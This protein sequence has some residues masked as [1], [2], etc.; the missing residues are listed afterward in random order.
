MISPDVMNLNV[1][2]YDKK[3]ST[4]DANFHVDTEYEPV[5]YTNGILGTWWATEKGITFNGANNTP[6]NSEFGLNAD[7][8]RVYPDASLGIPSSDMENGYI[9]DEAVGKYFVFS[10]I[11]S[12]YGNRR[13]HVGQNGGIGMPCVDFT[14]SACNHKATI[15]VTSKKDGRSCSIDIAC[16]YYQP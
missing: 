3:P 16:I 11:L 14:S 15:T 8:I 10:C 1:T 4:W 6:T 13:I 9:K 5:Y 12:E 2:I 7:F